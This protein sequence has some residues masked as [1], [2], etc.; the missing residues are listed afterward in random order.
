MRGR[1]AISAAA[2]GVVAAGAIAP[3]VRRRLR[4]PPPVVVA[5]AAAAPVALC[6]AVPRSRLRDVAV[7]CLQM[8]AYLTT[9]ELPHDDAERLRA[10]VRIRYPIVIDDVLGLG[11][12]PG[13]RLQRLMA[14]DG[15][16]GRLDRVLVWCHWVWFLVPHGSAAFVLLRR[17]EQ[18]KRAAAQIYGVFD[19]GVIAYWAIP[20]APPWYA[21]Q[22]GALGERT[23]ELRRMML[24]HGEAFWKTA[25]G[26]L[27]DVLGGNPLAAMPSLHFATSVMAAHVL[28]DAGPLPGTL[29]WSYA[30]TLG[31][32]L[33][34]LGEHYVAD[35]LAGLALAEGVR[36]HGHRAAP[37]LRAAVRAVQ[38]LESRAH[39]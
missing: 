18:F 2:W 17:P 37:A 20:T 7:V 21:A 19:L 9:Y 25:W 36:R 10:R 26:P 30:L 27:Y 3:I 23:P 33:V 11:D 8:K 16:T 4:L 5:A 35:L 15:A 14:R 22:V 1:I 31:F 13:L 38:H 32:A 29:G 34:Y 12:L 24:E 6:V 39:A 28:T